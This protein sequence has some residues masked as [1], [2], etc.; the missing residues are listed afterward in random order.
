VQELWN[1]KPELKRRVVSLF[2]KTVDEGA[3]CVWIVGSLLIPLALSAQEVQKR[4]KVSWSLTPGNRRANGRAPGRGGLQNSRACYR[5]R[6][7]IP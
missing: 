2:Q 6:P 3:R 1:N 5:S 4:I 7:G